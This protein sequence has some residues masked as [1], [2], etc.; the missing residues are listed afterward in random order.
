MQCILLN[1][2][3]AR[4]QGAVRAGILLPSPPECQL[5]DANLFTQQLAFQDLGFRGF[6]PIFINNHYAGQ[7]LRLVRS[8]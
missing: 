3:K 6:S 7:A 2:I 4:I 1:P 5:R 8:Q